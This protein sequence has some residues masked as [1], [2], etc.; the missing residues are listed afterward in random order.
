ADRGLIPAWLKSNQ[1]PLAKLTEATQRPRFFMPFNGGFRT[2]TLLEILLP[3]LSPCR[4]AANALIARA[5]LS[6]QAG[7]IDSAR[8]DLMTVHRL[9]RLFAQGPT[10]VERLV[11]YAIEGKASYSEQLLATA[12]SVHLT[13]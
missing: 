8:E 4:G 13:A 6:A 2:E 1:K 3:H 11:G 9:A 10:L 7:D 5:T 12:S